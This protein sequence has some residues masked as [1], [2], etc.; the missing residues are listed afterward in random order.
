MTLL[1]LIAIAWVLGGGLLAML[2][3]RVIRRADRP[4]GSD[5]LFTFLEADL[6]G[7]DAPRPQATAVR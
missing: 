4:T 3:A 7:D 5:S 2:V 1:L 6:R